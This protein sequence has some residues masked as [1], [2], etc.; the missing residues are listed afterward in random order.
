MST[1]TRYTHTREKNRGQH[2]SLTTVRLGSLDHWN[3]TDVIGVRE[4]GYFE[5]KPFELTANKKDQIRE[6]VKQSETAKVGIRVQQVCDNIKGVLEFQ[7]KIVRDTK[8]I[9]TYKLEYN[10]A[11]REA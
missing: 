8:S 11:T 9:G 7:V 5:A 1:G 6:I 3:T 10:R 4:L 2:A